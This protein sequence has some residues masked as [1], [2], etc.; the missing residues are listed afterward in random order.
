MI[1]EK[2]WIFQHMIYCDISLHVSQIIIKNFRHILSW[3]FKINTL[4]HKLLSIN[5]LHSVGDVVNKLQ[6]LKIS[7]YTIHS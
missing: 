3:G 6:D 4:L 5:L 1:S 2:Y 7:Y